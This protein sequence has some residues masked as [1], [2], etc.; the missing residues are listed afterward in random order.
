VLASI[1]SL[2]TLLFSLE[3]GALPKDIES[4][5]TDR[6]WNAL[7]GPNLH[8]ALDRAIDLLG[9]RTIIL[10]GARIDGKTLSDIQKRSQGADL[11]RAFREHL[12]IPI[13]PEDF[14]FFL[15]DLFLAPANVFLGRPI[16]LS[17][18]RLRAAG[19][20]LHPDGV[21]RARPRKYGENRD[22]ILVKTPVL[23]KDK[24]PPPA[25]AYLGPRWTNLY[26]EARS[27]EDRLWALYRKNPDF[28]TRMRSLIKQLRAQGVQL[29][30]ESTVRDRRRGFLIYGAFMLSRSRSQS[31][32]NFLLSR[33][34]RLQKSWALDLA[35][36]WSHPD[37]WKRTIHEARK[38]ADAFSVTYATE[39][40]ARRSDHYD[41]RAIDL[42]AVGLP[43][44]LRLK[45]PKGQ[46]KRF[47]LYAATQS[48]D[49]N[50]TPELVEW[51]EKHFELR[52]LRKDYPH[53]RDARR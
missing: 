5:K 10:A 12:R 19:I 13:D 30:V 41:G 1:F 45:S 43:R 50:L 16:D 8:K 27:A 4:I 24:R 34:P 28:A 46:T 25:G 31:K 2:S 14:L 52:K 53:W 51:I 26:Q 18:D 37:G 42:Y 7:P 23:R 3:L 40:G 22:R 29:S 15:D 33:L 32:V 9:R 17:P 44:T 11:T 49:L 38:M 47:D 6:N 48:R 21:F 39:N 35:I 36:N 20:L